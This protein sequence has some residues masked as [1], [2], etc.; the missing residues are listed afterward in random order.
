MI[1]LDKYKKPRGFGFVTY[2]SEHSV[3]AVLKQEIHIIS[4]KQIEC[5]PA[6]PKEETLSHTTAAHQGATSIEC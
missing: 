1:I 6:F 4:G 5:K 2:M 3:V